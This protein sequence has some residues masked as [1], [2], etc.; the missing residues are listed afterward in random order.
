[1]GSLWQGLGAIAPLAVRQ[2][3]VSKEQ[4]VV[5]TPGT[6]LDWCFKLKVVDLSQ[7]RLFV[8]DEADIMIDTQSL[9]QQS[10]RIQRCATPGCPL[11][12]S[13]GPLGCS[14]LREFATK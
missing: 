5:G 1:M 14:A 7:I 13:L 10:I 12:A 8:L 4:I 2:G 11:P 9:S 3:T 6:V